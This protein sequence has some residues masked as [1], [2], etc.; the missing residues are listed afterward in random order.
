MGSSEILTLILG[1]V[2]LVLSCV[3]ILFAYI[4][5]KRSSEN[6]QRTKDL[7]FE[8]DKRASVT[9]AIV[10]QQFQK[11]SDTMLDIVHATTTE[12]SERMAEIELKRA[13]TSAE[14]RTQWLKYIKEVSESGNDKKAD[15]MIKMFN[16][17]TTDK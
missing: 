16:G 4:A 7:L 5:E 1:V 2:A 11:M 15:L 14:M 13:E 17:M 9:E 10:G 8:I 6:H 12:P 3:S